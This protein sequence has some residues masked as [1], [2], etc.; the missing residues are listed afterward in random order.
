[1]I[2]SL[3]IDFY[4]FVKRILTSLSVDEMLPLSNVN[5]S[6]DSRVVLLRVEMAHFYL[7]HIY[8]GLL[9]LMWCYIVICRFMQKYTYIYWIHTDAMITDAGINFAER[10]TQE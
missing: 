4:A 10:K 5:W 1:M 9:A 3:S 8:T 6:I 7:K 2:N